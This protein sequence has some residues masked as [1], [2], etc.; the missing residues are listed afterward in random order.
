MTFY[1]Y[2]L[3]VGRSVQRDM[4]GALLTSYE[5]Q[6]GVCRQL[7]PTDGFFSL[8]VAA[9]RSSGPWEVTAGLRHIWIGSARTQNPSAAGV[10]L[11]DFS[12]NTGLAAGSGSPTLTEH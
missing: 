10:T 6:S 2:S 8:G 5:P 4:S 1:T 9:T 3:G 7:G 11:G 12:G